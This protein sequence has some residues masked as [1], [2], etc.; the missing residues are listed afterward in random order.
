MQM[1]VFVEYS[2]L[3]GCDAVSCLH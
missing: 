2:S 3:Q 1:C